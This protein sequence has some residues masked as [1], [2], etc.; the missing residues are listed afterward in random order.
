[1]DELDDDRDD[2]GKYKPPGRPRVVGSSDDTSYE[3]VRLLNGKS[4]LGLGLF[5][6]VFN[7]GLE[8]KFT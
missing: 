2:M 4:S 5:V 7:S 8:P 6:M 1:M 3:F